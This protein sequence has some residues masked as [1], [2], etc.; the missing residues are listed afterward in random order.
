MVSN[1]KNRYK[2]SRSTERLFVDRG[3]GIRTP[4][5]MVPNH[6]LYQTEPHPGD[7]HD[8][9]YGCGHILSTLFFKKSKIFLCIF[10]TVSGL[11]TVINFHTSSHAI[12]V[13]KKAAGFIRQPVSYLFFITGFYQ[14][15]EAFMFLQKLQFRVLQRIIAIFIVQLNGFLQCQ[16]PAHSLAHQ[17]IG[18]GCIIP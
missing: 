16:K 6:V 14:F 11:I 5:P 3:G 8:L 4:G 18:A 2:K 9:L 7:Q 12:K 10:H 17:R 1:V 13:Y 15:P